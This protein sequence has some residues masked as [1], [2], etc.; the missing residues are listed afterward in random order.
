MWG[1]D[2]TAF[3][4]GPTGPPGPPWTPGLT[5][6]G[7]GTPTGIKSFEPPGA[8]FGGAPPGEGDVND[9]PWKCMGGSRAL[10]RGRSSKKAAGVL[11]TFVDGPASG[12]GHPLAP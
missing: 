1:C 9:S 3:P 8:A 4:G 11:R 7:M 10:R 6:R 5:A 12:L 2:E